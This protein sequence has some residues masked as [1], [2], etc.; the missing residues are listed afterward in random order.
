[1]SSVKKV[2][3]HCFLCMCTISLFFTSTPVFAQIMSPGAML[4]LEVGRMLDLSS[5]FYNTLEQYKRLEHKLIPTNMLIPVIKDVDNTGRL[6]KEWSVEIA[7]HMQTTRKQIL[8][9]NILFQQKFN[10]IQQQI[11]NENKER[12]LQILET[13]QSDITIQKQ[14]VMKFLTAIQSFRNNVVISSRQLQ[15]DC[16]PIQVIIDIEEEKQGY[17]VIGENILLN[18]V[19][20]II[21]YINGVNGGTVGLLNN[22]ETMNTNW[23]TLEAK[24]QSLIQN[25]KDASDISMNFISADVQIVKE[26]WENIY[27]NIHQLY[28]EAK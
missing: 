13:V 2:I 19:L 20:D 9:Y 18:R 17:P 23:L 24:L 5:G 6:G 8:S 12:I 3:V 1:M 15:N 14:G 27:N 22:L 26:N 28:W 11:Q 10:D 4:N 7:P 21:N 25:I 16:I